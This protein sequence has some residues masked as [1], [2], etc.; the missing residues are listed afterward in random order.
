MRIKFSYVFLLLL[1]T[2]PSAF[3][4]S[5]LTSVD[6][7]QISA[8]I[9]RWNAVLRKEK[10]AQAESLYADNVIWYGEN[11]TSRDVITKIKD[12]LIKNK[13]YEQDIVDRIKIQPFDRFD[14]DNNKDIIRVNFVKLAGLT[15]EKQQY[16]P[17]EFLVKKETSGWRIISE[18]DNITQANQKK[19][20]AYLATKGKFDGK[21]A[22]Y[23]W[24]TEENPRTGGA[25]IDDEKGADECQCHLWNSNPKIQPVQIRQC[26]PGAVVTIKDLDGSGRDRIALMPDW[27][28]SAW[29]VIYLYDI[30]QGQWIK[31]MPS[32][33]MNINLQEGVTPDSLIQ[34]D[35][36]HPG[37]VKITDVDIDENSGEPV[38]KV[39]TSKLW[40]LK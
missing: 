5:A 1:C 16:Y 34:P 40:E 30:Q 2:L 12:F 20:R 29:R 18:T 9:E 25:C 24:M 31:T 17:A 6:E 3:A 7:Q 39:K 4:Q 13:Q 36:Q 19:D 33:A 23:A 22:S 26:L 27:W 38:I 32:F 10:G 28:S 21:S 35:L 37:M 11:M 15:S 8:L 14:I